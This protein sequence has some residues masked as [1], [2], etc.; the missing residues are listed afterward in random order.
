M[1]KEVVSERDIRDPQFRYV[2]N[3][4]EELEFRGDGQ[5]VFKRRW[6]SCV[7]QLFG[8][9]ELRD[10]DLECDKVVQAVKRL[11]YLDKKYSDRYVVQLVDTNE[12]YADEGNVTDPNEADTYTSFRSAKETADWLNEDCRKPAEIIKIKVKFNLEFEKVDTEE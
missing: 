3:P 6:E 1:S 12:Y 2:E 10:N 7:R 4:E 9:L 11:K 5:V 8:I